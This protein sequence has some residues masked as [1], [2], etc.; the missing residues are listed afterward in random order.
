RFQLPAAENSDVGEFGRLAGLQIL[1]QVPQV[2]LLQ[3]LD[4]FLLVEDGL[5]LGMIDNLS[6]G[7]LRRQH[8]L[9]LCVRG[10]VLELLA[11][12]QRKKRWI[13][14]KP[15]VQQ[16]VV[17]NQAENVR[18][19]VIILRRRVKRRDGFFQAAGMQVVPRL[20]QIFSQPGFIFAGR[21]LNRQVTEYVDDQSQQDGVS[22]A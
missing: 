8:V 9:K 1:Q 4:D 11:L 14:R 5:G 6:D 15:A 3:L 17:V 18:S 20:V 2:G 22:R 19:Q 12:G 7:S 10:D 16:R 13:G 21:D